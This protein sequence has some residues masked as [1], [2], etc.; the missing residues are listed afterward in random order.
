MGNDKRK[1]IFLFYE[2]REREEE[3][4]EKG[5]CAGEHVGDGIV[6]E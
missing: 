5:L 4:N 2:L 3:S 6:G 1:F